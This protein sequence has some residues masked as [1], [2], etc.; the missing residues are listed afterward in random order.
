MINIIIAIIIVLIVSIF[1][2]QNASPVAISFLFWQFQASLAIIIFLCV[3][4]GIVIGAALTMLFRINR[5]HKT[6]LT[7]SGILS[8][9][10][11]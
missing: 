8:D 7:S 4:S 9:R 5:K 2:V 11:E 10:N 6:K 3:L 1:S